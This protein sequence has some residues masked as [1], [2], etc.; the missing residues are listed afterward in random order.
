MIREIDYVQ[1]ADYRPLDSR[2]EEVFIPML[3]DLLNR[4]I[5]ERNVAFDSVVNQH[6]NKIENEEDQQ[7]I[8]DMDKV[9]YDTI[10]TLND[11]YL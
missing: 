4:A 11:E 7:W 8:L 10:E 6:S 1:L 2:R 3:I 9:I 5:D